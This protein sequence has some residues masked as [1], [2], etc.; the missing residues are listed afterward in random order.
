MRYHEEVI[1]D[2]LCLYT[3][4]PENMFILSFFGQIKTGSQIGSIHS[5]CKRTQSFMMF[6]VVCLSLFMMYVAIL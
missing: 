5:L 1:Q 4:M 6:Y 3:I 2:V